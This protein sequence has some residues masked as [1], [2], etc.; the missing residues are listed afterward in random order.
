MNKSMNGL[1][2]E[3]GNARRLLTRLASAHPG[4]RKDEV[5]TKQVGEHVCWGWLKRLASVHRALA[6]LRPGTEV[7]CSLSLGCPANGL[8]L[9]AQRTSALGPQDGDHARD[10]EMNR[11]VT[12]VTLDTMSG[13]RAPRT[14]ALALAHEL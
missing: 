10:K 14:G 9:C 3:S 4:P 2:H 1:I 8:I 12:C 11:I 13:S 6:D 5:F 7:Q